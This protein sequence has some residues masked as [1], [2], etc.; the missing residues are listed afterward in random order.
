MLI[1]DLYLTYEAPYHANLVKHSC[2]CP[3][4]IG[5]FPF[6]HTRQRALRGANLLETCIIMVTYYCDVLQR[7]VP[8][9]GTP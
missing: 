4:L 2:G 9:A 6:G 8:G 7:S 1:L 5:A 3:Q